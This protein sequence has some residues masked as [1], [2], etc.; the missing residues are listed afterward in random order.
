MGILAGGA[1]RHQSRYDIFRRSHMGDLESFRTSILSRQHEAEEALV[2][3]DVGPRLQMWSHTDPVSLFGAVGVSKTGW[4]E[5]SRTF[6]RVASRLSG[7]HDVSYELMAFD[8]GE[9]M[10]WTAG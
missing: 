10:A 3:G 7:G 5:L 2:R 9:D 4:D 6:H 8:V 1:V